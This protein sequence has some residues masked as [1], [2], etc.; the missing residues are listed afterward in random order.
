[1]GKSTSASKVYTDMKSMG[2]FVDS[3]CLSFDLDPKSDGSAVIREVQRWLE[4]Q[5]GPVLLLLDNAQRQHRLN[6]ILYATNIV[7]KSLVLIT[8]RERN[9]V[10]E[11]DLYDM[12]T[13]ADND[14]LE[15]FRWHSQGP[16]SS[17]LLKTNK[18]KVRNSVIY[19]TSQ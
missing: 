3:K 14:A 11:S 17:E 15:L 16:N 12:P 4:R 1:M 10:A 13:M 7:D 8:S 5:A 9:L 6:H 18:L 2:V 19:S